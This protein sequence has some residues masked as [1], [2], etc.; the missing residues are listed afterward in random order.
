MAALL[1]SVTRDKDKTAV[2]LNECRTMNIEVLTPSVNGSQADF[3]VLDGKIVFGLAAVRNVGEG[4]VGKIVE[5]R[6]EAGPFAD[7]GDF[8]DRV[9]MSALNRRTLESLIKAGAFDC[10]RSRPKGPAVGLRSDSWC[11]LGATA[12]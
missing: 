8:L 12:Q 5:A 6:L 7:Y 10:A 1:T 9:D 4:V 2:Y 3:T 11:H